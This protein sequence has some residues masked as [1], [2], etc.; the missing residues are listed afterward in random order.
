[1]PEAVPIAVAAAS[2]PSFHAMLGI[3]PHMRAAIRKCIHPG[4]Q[5]VAATTNP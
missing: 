5:T 1:M 3:I 2:S 4:G